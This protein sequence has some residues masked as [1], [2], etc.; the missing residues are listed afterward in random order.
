MIS[1]VH[2]NSKLAKTKV[3]DILDKYI[4]EVNL[5][6][7]GSRLRNRVYPPSKSSLLL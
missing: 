1:L 5:L 2:D 4:D 3:L 7:L 6:E